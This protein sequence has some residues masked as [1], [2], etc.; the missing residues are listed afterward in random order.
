MNPS[1]FDK[2]MMDLSRAIEIELPI[3]NEK[4]ALNAYAMMKDRIINEGTIGDGKSL[5]NYS[6]NK[7]PA[8]YFDGKSS[9]KG[10]DKLLAKELNKE[11]KGEGISYKQWRQAN[12]R[13]T[14]HVTL[15]FTGTTLNDIGVTK[16]VIEGGRV[17]TTVGPKNTKQRS[18]G[19]ST[20]E[21]AGYLTDQYGDILQPSTEEKEILQRFFDAEIQKIISKFIK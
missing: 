10:G 16:K 13:P 14:D 18:N 8:F 15:S 3:I 1:E 12:N 5:G 20:E 17:V 19:K 11:N 9:N 4:M 2:A 21:I 6:D 7:L